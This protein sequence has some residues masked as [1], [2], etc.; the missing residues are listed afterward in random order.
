[1]S[2]CA[3]FFVLSYSFLI[4][5]LRL[6]TVSFYVTCKSLPHIVEGGHVDALSS[7][8][9]ALREADQLR[10]AMRQC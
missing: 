1:M 7:H 10:D 3:F 9:P 5:L 2:F 8:I 4:L 6:I